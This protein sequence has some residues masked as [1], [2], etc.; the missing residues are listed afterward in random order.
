ML[1]VRK[2]AR[3]RN[4]PWQ[5]T[6]LVSIIAFVVAYCLKDS[7]GELV[8]HIAGFV[9]SGL[10]NPKSTEGAEAIGIILFVLLTILVFLFGYLYSIWRRPELFLTRNDLEKR[11]GSN[12]FATIKSV[13]AVFM[14]GQKF[15]EQCPTIPHSQIKLILP[16]P[17]SYSLKFL[18]S[19]LEYGT[20][21]EHLRKIIREA[22]A[23]GINVRLSE[24][25]SGSSWWIGDRD[26][27]DPFVHLEVALPFLTRPYR[28]SF[29][30]YKSQDQEFYRHYCEPF[31]KLWHRSAG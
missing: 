19:T 8:K 18:N 25:F 26:A 27:H 10:L 23:K 21:A 6:S 22:K 9:A 14:V 5:S 7:L 11:S 17:T 29:R 28:P 2:W 13:H 15:L 1:W 24:E 30:V 16:Q 12:A 4:A 3:T 20:D 31:D